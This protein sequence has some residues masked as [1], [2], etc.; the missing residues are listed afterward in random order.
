MGSTKNNQQ[1]ITSLCLAPLLDETKAVANATS[2]ARGLLGSC[3]KKACHDNG[4]RM[5]H[6]M[7]L[8]ASTCGSHNMAGGQHGSK[9]VKAAPVMFTVG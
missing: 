7:V 8:W 5:C 1:K 6:P 4:G 9:N 3:H 2:T